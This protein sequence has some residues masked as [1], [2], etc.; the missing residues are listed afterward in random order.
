MLDKQEILR[1]MG[2]T[3]SDKMIDRLIERAE[4]EVCQVSIPKHT[5]QRVS[6]LVDPGLQWVELAGTLIESHDLAHHLRGCKEGFLFACTLGLGVDSLVKRY[7]LTELAMLPVVQA[8][9]AAYIEYYA[10]KVQQQLNDS[11][12]QQGLYLRPRYSPGYGDFSL[13]YQR[14]LFNALQIS[15]QIG[16]SLTENFLMIPFKSIT[17]IIGLS[18]DPSLC[19]VNRCMIC[20]SKNCPFRKEAAINA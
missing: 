19:H 1:Y 20:V 14:F 16:V 2:A 4:R 6:I 9:S 5:Y 3:A 10:D 12:T 18:D 15:K 7:S 13:S 17:S 8:V 11:I